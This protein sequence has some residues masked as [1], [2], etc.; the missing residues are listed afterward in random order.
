MSADD[1]RAIECGGCPEYHELS[2][3]G[4]L[5]AAAGSAGVLAAA[6]AAPAWLPRVAVANSHRSTMRNVVI[7][8]FLRG[9]ADGLSMVVPYGDPGYY[10]ARPFLSVAPPNSAAPLR[11]ADINGYFGF[12]PALNLLR[13]AYD[14]GKLAIIH[15]TGST[16]PTRSHFDGQRYMESGADG[17]LSL[18]TGWLG[19]H[20]QHSAPHDPAALLRGIGLTTGLPRTLF[21]GPSS[22]PVPNPANFG[23]AGSADTAAARAAALHEMFEAVGDPLHAVAS[24]TLATIDLLRRINFNGY[25]PAGGAVYNTIGFGASLKASAALIKANVGVEAVAIDFNGWDTHA[26]QGIGP[27]GTMY[28][29]LNNLATNMMAFY[30][31]MTSGPSPGFIMVV[32]SEFGRRPGQNG[33]GGTDHG[34]GNCM[35]VMGQPVNGGQIFTDWPTLHDD[36]LYQGIDLDV[37]IDYRDVLSEIIQYGLNNYNLPQVFPG[38]D[39]TPR[40]VIV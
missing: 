8:V 38:F 5:R 40:G 31:D 17:H 11:C 18:S 29:L 21:G 30:R 37:T 32:M 4:F 26:N 20:L 22:L 15:A 13:P 34:H 10:S 9:G 36:R 39:P 2:R 6:A 25:Q 28:S 14:D 1:C 12:H 16:D 3:R 35:F 19:R 23:L 33:T 27:G 7:S 24:T